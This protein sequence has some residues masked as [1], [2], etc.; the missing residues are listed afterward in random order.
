MAYPLDVTVVEAIELEQGD[1]QWHGQ[2]APRDTLTGTRATIH[3]QGDNQR[4]QDGRGIA[5][6]EQPPECRVAAA[7]ARPWTQCSRAA[8]GDRGGDRCCFHHT[9]PGM[10]AP[11]PS[12]TCAPPFA[13][14]ASAASARRTTSRA[15]S[16][17]C[18]GIPRPA[19]AR[20]K[21][22]I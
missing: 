21:S 18:S 8:T 12:G 11:L 2:E 16:S 13:N 4:Q 7:A 10:S 3:H 9:A 19:I 17:R 20:K 15:K 5:Y 1:H 6:G 22:P 14:E